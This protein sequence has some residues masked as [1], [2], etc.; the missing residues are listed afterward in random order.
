MQKQRNLIINATFFISALLIAFAGVFLANSF[1]A[2]TNPQE[3]KRKEL[4]EQIKKLEEERKQLKNEIDSLRKQLAELEKRSTATDDRI[5]QAQER[6]TALRF[7]AGLVEVKGPG[8][9]IVLQDAD[10]SEDEIGVQG[11]VHDSDLRIIVNALLAA[12]AEAVSINGERY[13]SFSCIRC[14]GPT[15]LVNSRRMSSPFTIR[16]IGDPEALERGLIADEEAGYLITKVFPFYGIG[17][18]LT[19]EEEITVPSFKGTYALSYSTV[20]EEE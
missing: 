18:K 1:T 10:L 8:V 14:V 3:E 20:V 4:E 6:V 11:I 5:K 17:F 13:T 19:K 15:V 16:A 9:T 7:A 12:G 2:Y